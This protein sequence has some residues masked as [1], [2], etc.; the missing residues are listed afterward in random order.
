MVAKGCTTK[1]SLSLRFPTKDI[2][3]EHLL[4]HFIRGYFDGNGCISIN[5]DKRNVITNFVGTRNMLEG[6]QDYFYN[7]LDIRPTKIK[8]QGKAF[9]FS[10]GNVYAIHQIYKHLYLGANIF[11]D[12]KLKKFDTLFSLA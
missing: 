2:V 10:I 12:R 1:K 9:A 11:L 6:I 5:L 4:K 3:P 7:V 8:P